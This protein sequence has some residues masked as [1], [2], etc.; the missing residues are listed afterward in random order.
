[1]AERHY[2]LRKNVPLKPGQTVG[3][4]DGKGYYAKGRQLP[5][6][7]VK[8]PKMIL[9]RQKLLTAELAAARLGIHEVGG[10][11]HGPWVKRFLA[12]VGL[13]EG[14]AWCD[15]FQSFEEDGVAGHKLPIE[16]ASVGQTYAIAKQLGWLVT[17]PLS[18]DL[19]L[20][21]FDGDGQFDDHIELVD[22]VLALGPILT[23]RTIGGNTSSG[24]AGSQADG[25]GIWLRTRVIAANRVA[26]VRIP[27]KVAA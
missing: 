8:K 23:L 14:Y 11:N 3:F 15:A 26:F 13:P 9:I 16:S 25:D 7:P 22:K 20:F 18:R 17:R 24:I 1:M 6:K 10:N 2:T 5:P 4:T 21:D 19:A 12:E 27:G